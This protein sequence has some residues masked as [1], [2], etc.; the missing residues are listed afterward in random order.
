MKV[1]YIQ[2]MVRE[3]KQIYRPNKGYSTFEKAKEAFYALE[4]V[5]FEERV[6][7]AMNDYYHYSVQ[8]M[9]VE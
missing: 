8:L 9:E 1:W 3:S 2:V 4:D 7:V 6:L 5:E